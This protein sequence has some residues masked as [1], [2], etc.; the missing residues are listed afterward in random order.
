MNPPPCHQLREQPPS[1][2]L[3]P[4]CP[5]APRHRSG[6]SV[7]HPSALLPF[8]SSWT[9]SSDQQRVVPKLPLAFAPTALE[10]SNAPGNNIRYADRVHRG[11]LLASTGPS[12]WSPQDRGQ[13]QAVGTEPQCSPRASHRCLVHNWGA[14][15]WCDVGGICGTAGG[16]PTSPQPSALSLLPI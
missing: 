4:H 9:H 7:P 8:P 1:P 10:E 12:P 14:T 2:L 16:I 11:C 3:S 6:V 13:G 5:R 15:S